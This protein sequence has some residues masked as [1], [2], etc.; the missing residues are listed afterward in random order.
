MSI[1]LPSGTMTGP[2]QAGPV[3]MNMTFVTEDRTYETWWQGTVN[4][5]H[6]DGVWRLDGMP[7]QDVRDRDLVSAVYEPRDTTPK[8]MLTMRERDAECDGA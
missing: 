2:A 1:V 5:R 3:F 8:I 7:S 4:L 6:E